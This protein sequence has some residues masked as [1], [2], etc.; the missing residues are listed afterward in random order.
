MNRLSKEDTFS[1]VWM[2]ISQSLDGMNGTKKKKAQI[3]SL[4][5]LRYPTKLGHWHY[6]CWAFRPG[7][8]LHHHYVSLSFALL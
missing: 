4:L 7:P 6:G 8:E 2:D 1:P 3:H 5:E